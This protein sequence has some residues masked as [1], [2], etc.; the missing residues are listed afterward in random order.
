MKEVIGRT[1]TDFD[2]HGRYLYSRG[3]RVTSLDEIPLRHRRVVPLPGGG[4]QTVDARI[5]YTFH[6]EY[7]TK[8]SPR[9]AYLECVDLAMDENR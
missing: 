5:C 8:D 7:K 3:E 9:G 4:R 6:P 2:S 1:N